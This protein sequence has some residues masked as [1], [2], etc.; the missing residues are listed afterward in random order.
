MGTHSFYGGPTLK[1]RFV[2]AGA[3]AGAVVVAGAGAYGVREIQREA[4]AEE[5]CTAL[6]QQLAADGPTVT[7]SEGEPKVFILGDSY[8]T[9]EVLPDP[10][11]NWAHELGEAQGW[12]TVVDAIGG[13]GFMTGGYCG[14]DLFS[15]RVDHVLAESPETL[16]VQGGLNDSNSDPEHVEFAARTLL[17]EFE[18]VPNVVV[19]GPTLAPRKDNL[20]EIDAAMASAAEDAGA[21]YVSALDWELEFSDDR[22]HLTE[23]GHQQFAEKVAE[24]L[25]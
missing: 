25:P 20:D 2:I 22:L 16:I 11:Q 10:T 12:E 6:N 24:S 15:T 13:T 8:S 1:K 14:D 19:V 3:V 7:V 9:G 17:Q 21:H 5:R 23:A 18:S 4:H